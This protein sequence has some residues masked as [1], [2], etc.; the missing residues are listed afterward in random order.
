LLLLALLQRLN[1]GQKHRPISLF[2]A[3]CFRFAAGT[4][5]SVT[6]LTAQS[7]VAREGNLNTATRAVGCEH[8]IDRAPEFV[9]DEVAAIM[10]ATKPIMISQMMCMS[11]LLNSNLLRL[12]KCLS[13]RFSPASDVRPRRIDAARCAD[14]GNRHGLHISLAG[15]V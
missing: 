10:P 4:S 3:C 7:Q 13:K 8:E 14:P 6:S 2:L 5:S 12:S 1:I 11:V 15:M 9:R